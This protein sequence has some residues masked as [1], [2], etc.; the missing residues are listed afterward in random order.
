MGR[1]KKE[2]TTA[3]GR[4][5]KSLEDEKQTGEW[6]LK[7]GISVPAVAGTSRERDNSHYGTPERLICGPSTWWEGG[8]NAMRGTEM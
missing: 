5:P 3:C 4:H 2:K 1:E 7:K 6:Q 8:Q